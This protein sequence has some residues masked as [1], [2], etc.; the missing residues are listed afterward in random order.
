MNSAKITLWLKTG[1]TKVTLKEKSS[2]VFNHVKAIKGNGFHI[3]K[4]C[5]NSSEALTTAATCGVVTVRALSAKC[6]QKVGNINEGVRENSK[7]G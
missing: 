6:S 4:Q 5:S 2:I 3:P 7:T 1:W